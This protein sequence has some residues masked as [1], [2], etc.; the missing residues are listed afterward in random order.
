M[1]CSDFFPLREKENILLAQIEMIC[2]FFVPSGNSSVP[3]NLK[4]FLFLFFLFGPGSVHKART[5]TQGLTENTTKQ[6]T[7]KNPNLSAKVHEEAKQKGENDS[8]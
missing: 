7:H 4:Y 6:E 3:G 2:F 1:H 5:E 8:F